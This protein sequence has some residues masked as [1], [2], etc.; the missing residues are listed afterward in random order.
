M[1]PSGAVMLAKLSPPAPGKEHLGLRFKKPRIQALS[2]QATV[3]VREQENATMPPN[4][5]NVEVVPLRGGTTVS[6]QD[7]S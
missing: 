1:A 7:N 6:L 3:E 4:K 2:A 5:P